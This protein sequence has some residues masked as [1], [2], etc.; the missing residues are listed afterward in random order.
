MLLQISARYKSAVPRYFQNDE[1]FKSQLRDISA[2]FAV[3]RMIALTGFSRFSRFYYQL[4]KSCPEGTA[5]SVGVNAPVFASAA[6]AF[7]AIGG[8]SVSIML[9]FIAAGGLKASAIRVSSAA[10]NI[11]KLVVGE[12]ACFGLS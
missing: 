7:Y 9:A 6:G 3:S 11:V 8:L 12:L 10:C 5:D 4:Y 2:L 1:K